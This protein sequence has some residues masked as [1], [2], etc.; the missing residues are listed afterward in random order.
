MTARRAARI[1]VAASAPAG[2]GRKAMACLDCLGAAE[3][4]LAHVRCR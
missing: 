1:R 2:T 3:P 4:I